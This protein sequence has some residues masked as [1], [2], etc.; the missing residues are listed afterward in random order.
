MV[1]NFI[2]MIFGSVSSCADSAVL[3]GLR[4]LV[5]GRRLGLPVLFIDEISG[6]RS[7]RP[8]T[9]ISLPFNLLAY[10]CSQ[11]TMRSYL[12]KVSVSLRRDKR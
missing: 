12:R 7:P 4:I 9:V 3:C 2:L 1:E 8:L 10:L 11:L 5:H 6:G